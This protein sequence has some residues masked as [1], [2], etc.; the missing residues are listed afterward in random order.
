MK[1]HETTK[2]KEYYILTPSEAHGVTIKGEKIHYSDKNS[3]EVFD[4]EESYIAKLIE[5]NIE[6]D[7]DQ[8]YTK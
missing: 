8:E 3:I 2:E 6:Y 4:T 1:K 5:L 7:N